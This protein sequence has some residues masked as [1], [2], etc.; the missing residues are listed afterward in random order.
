MLKSAHAPF[1]SGEQGSRL[2]QLRLRSGVAQI[3]DA[4][5]TA[6]I[7]RGLPMGQVLLITKSKMVSRLVLIYQAR[8]IT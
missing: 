6:K 4:D 5:M 8:P 7:R 1:C 3:S 2:S